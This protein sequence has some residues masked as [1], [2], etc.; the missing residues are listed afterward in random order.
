[1]CLT[2]AS[3]LEQ[4][5]MPSM[6]TGLDWLGRRPAFVCG[7]VGPSLD[8]KGLAALQQY[9]ESSQDTCC[10]VSANWLLDCDEQRTL[11]VPSRMHLLTA[12]HISSKAQLTKVHRKW[13]LKIQMI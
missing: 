6:Q 12:S 8:A 13:Y 4:Y 1:V 2:L 11:V 9:Y 10:L 7:Q 5:R 3:I